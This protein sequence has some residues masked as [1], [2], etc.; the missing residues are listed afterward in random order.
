[1]RLTAS[2]SASSLNVLTMEISTNSDIPTSRVY[3][4]TSFSD[5]EVGG[6]GTV[7]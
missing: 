4:L 5:S 2:D 3:V 7:A 6:K 1:M